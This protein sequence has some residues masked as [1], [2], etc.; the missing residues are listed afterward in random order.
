MRFAEVSEH[1]VIAVSDPRHMTQSELRRL[2]MPR[3]VYLR[4]GTVDGEPAYAIHAA[5]GTPM[6]VV[7]DVDIAIELASANDM[8]F[9]AVH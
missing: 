1:E 8:T 3:L 6:A 2:G 4:C 9:V 5:D 7:E